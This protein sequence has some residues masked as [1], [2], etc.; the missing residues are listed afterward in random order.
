[1]GR[2][3]GDGKGEDGD[4]V[5]V[6]EDYIHA[7]QQFLINH[8]LEALEAILLAEDDTLH[9]PLQV[10]FAELLEA[11]PPLANLIYTQP[12]RFL[13]LFDN[14]A[15]LAQSVVLE[16]HKHIENMS[17]KGNVHVR[18]DVNGSAMDCPETHPSIGRVR[19]KDMGKL[20]TLQ[21][22]VIRS[23]AIKMLEGEREYECTKCKHR[24]KVF[25]ELETGNTVRQ[26]MSCPSQRVN[27]C[28]GT[29]FKYIEDSKM[30]H[31]YQEIKIQENMQSL[32]VGS[33]PRSIPVVLKDDLVDFVKAGDD[34]IVTGLLFAKWR[35]VSKD[36]RCDLDL[37]LLAN[38]IRR[39]NELK[40][41]VDI[42]EEAIKQFEGFWMHFK[43]NPLK[44]R[45][46]ILQGICPQVY[47]LF[48]VK[49]AD[50]SG[51]KVRGESHFLLVGDPGEWMLE[52]GALVLA[53]GGLC[54]IDEFDSIREPDRA[55]IHEAMEQQTISVAKAGLVTTLNTRT[56]VFGVTN[57]KGQYDP[58]RS[59]SVNTSLSSPLLSRFDIILVLLDTKKPDWDKIVSSHILSEHEQ[60]EKVSANDDLRGL[61]TL[62]MLRRYIHFVKGNFRPVLT[63]QAERVISSYYQLQR[64]SATQNAARTTIRML[65]S[66]IRLAQAHARLMFRDEVTRLDAISAII[67]VESSMTTSAILDNVGNVL[68]S[69]FTENPDEEY[70][71]QEKLIL[72][73][74]NL[75]DNTFDNQNGSDGIAKNVEA[76]NHQRVNNNQP[77]NGTNSCNGKSNL[78]PC[79]YGDAHTN[80]GK[81][82]RETRVD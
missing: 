38:Y 43:D 9:Y 70:A 16:A 68:H 22:T 27:R 57:P 69:S 18:L 46:I 2:G 80:L 52:A 74:L 31:D 11:S 76:S 36:V 78:R 35:P 32:G 8:H 40:L 51:T 37:V 26:P 53:D 44:G 67:C 29:N 3:F 65:E 13:P 30:C 39:T 75:V 1:M 48:T 54:C 64:R 47:G 28:Q 71:K 60:K 24:F 62:L 19:V 82:H 17:V 20:I 33:V 41:A 49:L 34:I 63:K 81:S 56:T 79:S 42:S 23:G 5:V 21:G 25:P 61:W 66:L 72:E 15:R 55:T 73:K 7:F 14:A 45:N 58:Y 10:D 12:A 4:F 77:V 50:A 59:L 6:Q